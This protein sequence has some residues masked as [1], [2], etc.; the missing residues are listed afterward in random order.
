MKKVFRILSALLGAAL[1]LL[2]LASCLTKDAPSGVYA[3]EG[4]DPLFSCKFEGDGFVWFVDGEEQYRTTFRL[5]YQK[6][7]DEYPGM[8]RIITPD[9]PF[10]DP[11]DDMLFWDKDNDLLIRL[12]YASDGDRVE[13]RFLPGR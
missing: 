5:A 8:F 10:P 4:E 3:E 6:T 13:S 1:A 12:T 7:G 9:L 11:C 2:P